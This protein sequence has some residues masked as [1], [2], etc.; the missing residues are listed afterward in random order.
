MVSWTLCK[1]ASWLDVS[2]VFCILS[3]ST[4]LAFASLVILGPSP[5]KCIIAQFDI[6]K[7]WASCICK[8]AFC[9][10]THVP[11]VAQFIC[12][13]ILVANISICSIE[14]IV[15]LLIFQG[16]IYQYQNLFFFCNYTQSIRI[17]VSGKGTV[18]YLLPIHGLPACHDQALPTGCLQLRCAKL[19]FLLAF[20]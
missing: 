8:L 6:S 17:P 5:A 16:L 3:L 18:S 11:N 4:F 10:R 7:V 20:T 19:D 2:R 1:L 12:L 15:P 9:A 14:G 13:C